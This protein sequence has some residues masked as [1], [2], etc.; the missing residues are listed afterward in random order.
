MITAL[1]RRASE[2]APLLSCPSFALVPCTAIRLKRLAGVSTR[3]GELLPCHYS[4]TQ[5][6]IDSRQRQPGG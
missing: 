4:K 6:R 5:N 3:K 1:R 2:R